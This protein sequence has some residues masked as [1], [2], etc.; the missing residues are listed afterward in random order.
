MR[1]KLDYTENWRSFEKYTTPPKLCGGITNQKPKK[2]RFKGGPWKRNS[3]R[4]YSI[5]F[6]CSLGSL[7]KKPSSV[8]WF[9]N[10][11]WIKQSN[12]H[13]ILCSKREDRFSNPFFELVQKMCQFDFSYLLR[14]GI[15]CKGP[16]T[17]R[18]FPQKC[19]KIAGCWGCAVHVRNL[20]RTA[21]QWQNPIFL[22][23][24]HVFSPEVATA[25]RF[26]KRKSW[27]C[28]QN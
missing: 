14:L 28:A 17:L 8:H 19:Q 25:H 20:R 21:A 7:V 1:C 16:R 11:G 24:I 27:S 18:K 23:S 22:A 10:I 3:R 12:T 5:V 13:E 2:K 9:P 26:S 6:T 15:F 4:R